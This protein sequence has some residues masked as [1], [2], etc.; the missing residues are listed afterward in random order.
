MGRRRVGWSRWAI[1]GH[2]LLKHKT[3]PEPEMRRHRD[4]PFRTVRCEDYFETAVKR[5]GRIQ[6]GFWLE[7]RFGLGGWGRFEAG[8]FDRNAAGLASFA[9]AA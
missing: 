4:P 5:F 7:L 2:Q 1:L 6:L 8:R 3:K 9:H